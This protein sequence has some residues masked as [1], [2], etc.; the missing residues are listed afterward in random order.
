MIE[1]A[2]GHKQGLVLQGPV[3][4]AAG[5]LGF[6]GEYRGLIELAKLGAFVTNPVTLHPRT[7][8]HAPN[9]VELANGLLIHTGLPNPGMRR[10]LRRHDAEWRRL[11]APVIL[12]LAATTAADVALAVEYVERAQGVSGLELGLRDDVSAGECGRLVRAALGGL[13]VLVRLPLAR[14]GALA[15]TAAQAGADALVVAAP[16]RLTVPHAGREV[17]GRYYGPDTFAPALEALGAVAALGLGVPLIAAGGVY[18]S[19]N[20]Q[21]ML[22]AGAVAVQVDGAAWREPRIMEVIGNW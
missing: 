7:P 21:A 4:N 10:A 14:A 22:A 20:A 8:A 3:M 11:G 17:T 12:H 13:P 16:P 2:P 19:E 18:S 5:V 1:L 15:P 6:A 9:A